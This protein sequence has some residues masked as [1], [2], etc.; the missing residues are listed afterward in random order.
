[1]EVYKSTNF[2]GNFLRELLLTDYTYLH[3]FSMKNDG[4]EVLRRVTG[5]KR[6]LIKIYVSNGVLKIE[7][8]I[9]NKEPTLLSVLINITQQELQ[10]MQV[11]LPDAI[12]GGFTV[13]LLG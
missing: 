3:R 11:E 12:D 13:Q 10:E 5:K 4:P 6:W 7:K 9:R 2:F 8:T 1:M